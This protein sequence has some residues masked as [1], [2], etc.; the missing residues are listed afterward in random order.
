M[1]YQT[2]KTALELLNTGSVTCDAGLNDDQSAAATANELARRN[3]PSALAGLRRWLWAQILAPMVTGK[4]HNQ[5]QIGTQDLLALDPHQLRDMNL[6]VTPF[7]QLVLAAPQGQS[8]DLYA[9]NPAPAAQAP[10]AVQP[11]T[12]PSQPPARP[13]NRAA[14]PVPA[15][16]SF[17]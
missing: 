8:E 12:A 7:G 15:A 2:A 9:A 10:A 4:A 17:S 1:Y 14:F 13:K 6:E 3:R 5:A 11:A 16:L